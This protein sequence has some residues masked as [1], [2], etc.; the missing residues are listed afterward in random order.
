M[1]AI[2][3]RAGTPAPVDREAVPPAVDQPVV[4]LL[5]AGAG[6]RRDVG[7]DDGDR[8]DVH[9]MSVVRQPADGAAFAA[10][11]PCDRPPQ[12]AATDGEDGAGGNL[13]APA[14]AIRTRNIAFIPICCK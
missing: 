8:R 7:A 2:E 9:G 3:D 1:E 14:R 11:G 6:N 13:P 12:G 5:H 10:S 4:L